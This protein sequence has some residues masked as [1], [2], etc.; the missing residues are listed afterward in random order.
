[1]YTPLALG[2]HVVQS[3]CQGR[4]ARARNPV[5][6]PAA[7]LQHPHSMS[8]NPNHNRA[9]QPTSNIPK[10]QQQPACNISTR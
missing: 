8:A 4:S 6:S 3:I 9:G 5:V 10:S 2:S 7:S 1:M